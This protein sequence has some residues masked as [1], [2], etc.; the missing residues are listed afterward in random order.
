MQQLDQLAASSSAQHVEAIRRQ[1]PQHAPQHRSTP[2]KSSHP[3]QKDKDISD[4]LPRAV[5]YIIMQAH[6]ASR[7]QMFLHRLCCATEST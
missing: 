1:R 6:L 2:E 5:N 3:P 7:I 4:V